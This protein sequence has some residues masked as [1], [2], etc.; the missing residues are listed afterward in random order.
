MVAKKKPSSPGRRG[1]TRT[2]PAQ[3]SAAKPPAKKASRVQ[4]TQ[5]ASPGDK[6][7]YLSQADVP[8]NDIRDALRVAQTLRDAYAGKPATPSMVAKGLNDMAV[9]GG[10][11]K[12]LTGAS[13]AY[14][15]TEG[16]AQAD[17]I[18]LTSLGRRAV[19][20]TEEGD[21]LRA[22]REAVLRPRV[23]G[24]FLRQYNGSPLPPENIGKNVLESMG[25]PLYATQR[26]WDLICENA[27]ELG[28]SEVIDGRTVVRL[29]GIAMQSAEID[30][31]D[32]AAEPEAD[33]YEINDTVPLK[34]T[35]SPISAAQLGNRVFI[36]HGKNKDIVEQIKEILTFGKFAPVVS[37][38]K[39]AVAKPVPDK[40]LDDMRSC[41]A[42]IVHVSTD[43]KL[44]N[45]DGNEVIV[46]NPNV[47]IEIGAAMALYRRRFVLLVERGVTLPSNLQGLYEVR[48]EGSKL[49]YEATMKL[50]K[51][52]NEFRD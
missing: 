31:D 22:L 51:A 33:L 30:E 45:T 43:Q 26:A 12:M 18:S 32:R 1:P 7:Q 46:L 35:E 28:L 39:E 9:G 47:L 52:F 34:T 21:D 3:K 13:V 10:Q 15:L 37:I 6:R 38:E 44:M 24:D 20:P 40:V 17:K 42:G 8:G 16:A 2:T 14:G 48:Y 4:G 50:L 23:V 49:D 11:F 41:F 5:V 36:T 19:A 25:V 27:R 29:D